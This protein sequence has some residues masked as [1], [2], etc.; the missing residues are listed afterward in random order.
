MPLAFIHRESDG[1]DSIPG[2]GTVDQAVHPSG[3]SKLVAVNK[4]W[5]TAAELELLQV[6][7]VGRKMADLTCVGMSDSCSLHG[8][9]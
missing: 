9:P 1:P 7:R 6:K 2:A 3:V 4:K 8:R 5:V